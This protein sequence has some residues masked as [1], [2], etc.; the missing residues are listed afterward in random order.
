MQHT[1]RNLLEQQDE[2][3]VCGVAS[4]GREA[5]EKCQQSE[6]DVVVM[7]FQMPEMNGLDAAREINRRSRR[8]PILM[9]TLHLTRQLADEARRVGIRGVCAKTAIGSLVQAV[10]ALLRKETYFPDCLA[11]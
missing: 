6:P 10:K 1:L 11:A 7:D 2:W 4:N 8:A 5:V 9:V 3:K